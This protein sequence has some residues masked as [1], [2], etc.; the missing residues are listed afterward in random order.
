[1]IG[2]A[3]FS[4]REQEINVDLNSTPEEKKFLLNK[5]W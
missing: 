5:K 1:M 3:F 4:E 2:L